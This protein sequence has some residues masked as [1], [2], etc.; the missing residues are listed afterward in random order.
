MAKKNGIE[1]K[2]DSVIKRLDQMVMNAKPE[3]IRGY[4]MRYVLPQYK[5]AQRERWASE[6]N[7]Q[8]TQWKELASDAYAKRK[9]KLAREKGYPGGGT[10]LMILSGNLVGAATGENKGL[11]VISAGTQFTIG[12]STDAVPYAGY[13]SKARPIMQFNKETIN[14]WV[15]PLRKLLVGGKL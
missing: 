3:A 12:V 1:F 7:T 5:N 14:E 10:K 15:K 13:A 8:G 4:F 9:I 2:A 6:N 11:Y